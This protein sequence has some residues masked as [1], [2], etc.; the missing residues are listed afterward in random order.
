MPYDS[1]HRSTFPT[2]AA[3]DMHLV[4]IFLPIT[5]NDGTPF[6]P[7]M[8]AQIREELTTRFGGVTAFMRAPAHGSFQSNGSVAR[9]DIVIFEVMTPQLD[10][11]WWASYRKTLE[12]EFAQDEIVIRTSTVERL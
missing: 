12:A 1:S 10:R 2:A 8:Y 6:E 4:E 11:Q 9:D 7:A 5:G 3:Q